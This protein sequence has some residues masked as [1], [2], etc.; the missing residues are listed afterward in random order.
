MGISVYFISQML[1]NSKL[2]RLVLVS[3]KTTIVPKVKSIL[4]FIFSR[5]VS[6]EDF[7]QSDILL[8]KFERPYTV[9]S[10]PLYKI[11]QRF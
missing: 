9:S 1:N 11:M 10:I 8:F 6:L 7:S 4:S 5:L 3:D 2:Q